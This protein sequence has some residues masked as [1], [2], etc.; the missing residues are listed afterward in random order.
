MLEFIRRYRLFLL[1]L[2]VGFSTKAQVLDTIQLDFKRILVL[3]DTIYYGARDSI[4]VLPADTEYQ[5][6]KNIFLR[7]KDYYQRHPEKGASVEESHV[8]FME[9]IMGQIHNKKEALPEDFNPSDDYFKYYEGKAIK[10]IYYDQTEILDGSVYDTTA[11]KTTSFGRF[12]SKSYSPTKT[13]VLQ[14]N[15]RFKE[16]ERVNPRIFSDNERILRTLPYMEDA[17]IFI[18]PVENEPD[19]VNVSVVTKDKYPIGISGDVK[20]ID[21]IVV[22]PYNRNFLGMGHRLGATMEYKGSGYKKLGYGMDYEIDNVMGTF[23][24]AEMAYLNSYKTEVFATRFEKPFISTDTKYG[25]EVSYENI[26]TRRNSPVYSPDSSYYNENFY[27]ANNYDFWLGYSLFLSRDITKP[28]INLGARYYAEVYTDRP[29]I[30]AETNFSFHDK[31]TF[32]GAFSYQQVSYLKT[33]KLLNMGVIEDVPVGF[34]FSFIAGW[35]NTSYYKRSYT[36]IGWNY[37]KL[38]Q[39]TGL[40]TLEANVGGYLRNSK[41]E[42]AVSDLR[43]RYY[44]PLLKLADFELRHIFAVNYASIRNPLY[45]NKISFEDIVN[46]FDETEAYGNG[47]MVLRYQP[48]LFTPYKWLGFDVAFKPFVYM[49]WMSEKSFW[50]SPKQF[51]TV[52][53][54]G[55]SIKNESL[56][57]PTMSVYAGFYSKGAGNGSSFT[58]EISFKDYRILDFFTELKPTTAHPS[59]FYY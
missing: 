20:D 35:Q 25:G 57:F 48:I 43:F 47:T 16:H 15:V 55:G 39:N 44:S 56:I 34:N 51:Y 3:E 45:L 31:H 54:L 21:Y 24:S 14:N 40:F 6:F 46:G 8:K 52:Y 18:T 30:D 5:T 58:F 50:D 36:G 9:F 22:E 11:T 27:T 4:I 37:S 53:G 17:K 26:T 41:Y 42:D 7:N 28:F 29:D 19:S 12:L 2:L 49:G 1:L 13:R 33:T 38:F 59:D 32:L 23:I 10:N